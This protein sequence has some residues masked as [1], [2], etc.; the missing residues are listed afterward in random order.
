[1]YGLQWSSKLNI[2]HTYIWTIFNFH[3]QCAQMIE[4]KTLK[5]R[6]VLKLKIVFKAL[7]SL[8]LLSSQGN[9]SIQNIP[10]LKTY[11]CFKEA[12]ITRIFVWHFYLSVN[13]NFLNNKRNCTRNSCP[14][15]RKYNQQW[16]CTNIYFQLLHFLWWNQAVNEKVIG[17]GLFSVWV[18]RPFS[19]TSQDTKFNIMVFP[20]LKRCTQMTCQGSLFI[21]H[22]WFSSSR[23]R[24]VLL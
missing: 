9:K 5:I 8:N 20:Q 2:A 13:V 12:C 22:C 15:D 10:H 1:M 19:N 24:T 7:T 14:Q 3:D 16:K 17:G 21:Q 6:A 18:Q 23:G 11:V 4:R